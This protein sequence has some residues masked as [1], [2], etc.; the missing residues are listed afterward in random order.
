MTALE[1]RHA[2]GWGRIPM[3]DG[4]DSLNCDMCRAAGK[5]HAGAGTKLIFL[6]GRPY[7][8]VCLAHSKAV[9]ETWDGALDQ[10]HPN[11]VGEAV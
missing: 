10:G 11:V 6:L 4:S 5:Q 8:R 9:R 7:M 1:F 3:P 2:K